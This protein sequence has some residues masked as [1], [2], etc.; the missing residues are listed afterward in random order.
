MSGASTSEF[1]SLNSFVK[2]FNGSSQFVHVKYLRLQN[3]ETPKLKV[4]QCRGIFCLKFEM[5]LSRVFV[6]QVI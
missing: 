4:S 3:I 1:L 2:F 6:F 5:S